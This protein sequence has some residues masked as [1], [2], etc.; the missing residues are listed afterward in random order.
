MRG[1]ETLSELSPP[2]WKVY[3]DGVNMRYQGY[4]DG[5]SLSR[6]WLL[7]GQVEAGRLLLEA[8][9]AAALPKLGLASSHCPVKGIF[10]ETPSRA[11]S[12]SATTAAVVEEAAG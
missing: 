9:W 4:G 10:P 11:A 2:T 7:H 5:R 12:S 8:M 1:Q 6:S 3:V